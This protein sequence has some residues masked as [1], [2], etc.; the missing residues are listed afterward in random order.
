[1]F[2]VFL[3]HYLLKKRRLWNL[4]LVVFMPWN[5]QKNGIIVEMRIWN[6]PDG[7]PASARLTVVSFA[8]A[9]LLQ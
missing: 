5:Y 3:I 8:D 9:P 1:M 4:S 2:I 7:V 6:V